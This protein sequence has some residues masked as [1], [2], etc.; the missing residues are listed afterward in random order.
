MRCY[1][2]EKEATTTYKITEGLII[3]IFLCTK[4]LEQ[5][6]YEELKA[7]LDGRIILNLS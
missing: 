7:F 3:K 6:E 5:I 4:C 1:F 2:C